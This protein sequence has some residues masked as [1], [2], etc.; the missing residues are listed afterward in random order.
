MINLQNLVNN[1]GVWNGAWSNPSGSFSL[2]ATWWSNNN[3]ADWATYYMW[4]TRRTWWS[5]DANSYRIRIPKKC[6]L[7]KCF[8][9]SRTTT[10]GSAE[11]STVSIVV[12]GVTEYVIT[13]SFKNDVALINTASNTNMSIMLNKWDYICI[14]W[15]CPTRVLNP[16]WVWLN[17]IMRFD[18]VPT[19]NTW[20]YV[21][22]WWCWSIT[23]VAGTTYNLYDTDFST[24]N[25]TQARIYIPA[26][27]T[28]TRADIFC[29]LWWT[30]WSNELFTFAIRKNNSSNTDITTTATLNAVLN[31][32]TNNWLSIPVTEWDYI[33]IQLIWPVRVT[34]PT[35]AVFRFSFLIN[36]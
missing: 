7:K 10:A 18:G 34:P 11:T 15:V 8:L 2:Q 13:N 20:S 23:W 21:L 16:I 30:L 25:V 14:K 31:S 24:T 17:S 9:S 35:D 19:T 29:R 12:N 33:C 32:F 4:Q 27:W 1:S 28:I 5:I 3:P 22:Q 36:R 26:T 6:I